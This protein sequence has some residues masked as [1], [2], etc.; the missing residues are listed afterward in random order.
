MTDQRNMPLIGALVALTAGTLFSFGVVTVRLAEGLD[1]FQYL[2]WRAIALLPALVVIALWTR[3]NPLR[4]ALR[5]GWL[6]LVGAACLTLASTSFVFALKETTVANAM[7]FGSCSPLIGAFLGWAMLRERIDTRIWGAI[8]LGLAGLGIM[9]YSELGAGKLSG[10]LAALASAFGYAGYSIVARLGR[11][12]DLSGV[13]GLYGLLTLVVAYLLAM[14]GS[15]TVMGPPFSIAMAMLHGA[16]FIA[17]GI[18]SFNFAAR[19]VKAAQ[20]T[21]LGQT[22]TIFAPL[23]VLILFGETPK[24]ATLIGGAFIIAAVLLTARAS[25]DETA[26][27]TASAGAAKLADDPPQDGR[28]HDR[29]THD[30][31]NVRDLGEKE[32]HP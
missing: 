22:E 6:G 20:L 28:H 31:Q 23:W 19:H 2:F 32:K 25:T 21:L 12:R 24:V 17:L 1:A 15:D 4:Q 13:V 11:G 30:R 26:E 16:V 10:N 8:A 5:A 27:D 18:V 3:Q 14:L 29:P 7:L 9:T